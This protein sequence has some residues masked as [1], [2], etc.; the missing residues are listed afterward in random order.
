MH[1]TVHVLLLHVH[2]LSSDLSHCSGQGQLVWPPPGSPSAAG[3]LVRGGVQKL[4]E[5]VIICD[6]VCRNQAFVMEINYEIWAFK[7]AVIVYWES[8]F[9]RTTGFPNDRRV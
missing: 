7:A 8:L 2:C 9:F 6:R 1:S 3:T 5:T 4:G